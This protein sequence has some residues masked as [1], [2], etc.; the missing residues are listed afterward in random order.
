MKNLN[1]RIVALFYLALSAISFLLAHIFEIEGF[2]ALSS[3]RAG[4][5]PSTLLGVS[6]AFFV[7]SISGLSAEY[8]A[9]AKRLNRLF[10]ELLGKITMREAIVFSLASGIG[11]ELFFRAFLIPLAGFYIS[12][13]LFALMHGAFMRPLRAWSLF[14]LFSGAILGWLFIFTGGILA[15]AIA[16]VLVNFLSFRSIIIERVN[17]EPPPHAP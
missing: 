13:I 8:F 10:T 11:E 12:T 6:S 17:S 2:G 3:E 5:I 1:I 16:H 4:L 7:F 9:W 15:P 14:A